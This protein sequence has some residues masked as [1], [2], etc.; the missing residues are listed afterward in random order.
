MLFAI[1]SWVHNETHI[2]M[3][4][5]CIIC[6]DLIKRAGV[7]ISLSYT[8]TGANDSTTVVGRFSF[9]GSP[10]IFYDYFNK[11][12]SLYHNLMPPQ[13]EVAFTNVNCQTVI[14]FS[15]VN[16]MPTRIFRRFAGFIF[17]VGSNNNNHFL[18]VVYII[19]NFRN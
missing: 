1:M 18:S 6:I 9:Q 13:F 7:R 19:H 10:L 11:S 12:K 14:T 8:C 2:R 16:V 3:V 5:V 15:I 4:T 17:Q